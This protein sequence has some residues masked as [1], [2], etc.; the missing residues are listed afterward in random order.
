MW[1]KIMATVGEKLDGLHWCHSRIWSLKG[2]LSAQKTTRLPEPVC[3]I[4]FIIPVTF[5]GSGM[6]VLRD[7]EHVREH[8]GAILPL[9]KQLSSLTS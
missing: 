1:R 4:S 5:T 2:R 3:I 7:Q 8:N 9:S 6:V